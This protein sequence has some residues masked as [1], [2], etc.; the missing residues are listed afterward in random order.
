MLL[1]LMW[2]IGAGGVP[3]IR[4]HSNLVTLEPEIARVLEERHGPGLTIEQ[5]PVSQAGAALTRLVVTSPAGESSRYVVK[6]L[7]PLGDWVARAT[8]DERIRELQLASG[9]IYRALPRDVGSAVLTA[10]TF[11]D[12]STALLMRDVS[13]SLVSPGDEP[14]SDE[15]LARTLESL[16][17]LHSAFYGF[18]ARLM[19]GLGLCLLG[20]W[21]TLFA[22]ATVHRETVA[23]HLSPNLSQILD[24]WTTF[25]RLAPGTWPVLEPL[26]IEPRPVVQALRACPDTFLHGDARVEHLA[27][28]NDR[29]TLLDWG[30][31]LRGPGA[32]DLGWFLAGNADQ[33]ALEHDRA[34]EIY[35]RERERLRRLPASGEQW[36]RELDLS[37][38]VGV[39]RGGWALALAVASAD[40]AIRRDDRMAL[41]F[42]EEAVVR[43]QRWL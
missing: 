24:G 29:I 38:L 11:Q 33:N 13:E 19:V 28:E 17:R 42:W 18:P 37:L 26:L 4:R 7:H 35:R 22:P 40:G 27:F 34:I 15:Q 25:A 1:A 12:G 5:L 20:D 3:I 16:A 10:T 8:R 14:L 6:R 32:L 43:A 30:Q 39:M 41:A 2:I 36:E 21:L 9:G 23:G 31:F